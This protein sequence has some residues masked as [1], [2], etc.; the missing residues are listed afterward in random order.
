MIMIRKNSFRFRFCLHYI[1]IVAIPCIAFLIQFQTEALS[2]DRRTYVEYLSSIALSS[3][4]QVG[5]SQPVTIQNDD[6]SSSSVAVVAA[7]ADVTLSN[8]S[9]PENVE[10][11]D[12]V[13]MD[14]R[15]ARSD[16]ST[17][18]RDDLPD[19]FEN[20][21]LFQRITI[22]LYGTLMPRHVEK[23]LSYIEPTTNT[24]NGGDVYDV[25]NP[26]PSYSRSN[27][28]AL[29]QE[30]GLLMAGSI[31]S[32][33]SKDVAGT[34][35]LTYGSRVLPATLWIENNRDNT[36]SNTAK[37]TTTK[38][39]HSTKGLL[40]HRNLDVL[41]NFGI[42]TR[43]APS[44][45]GSNT[46]FGQVLWDEDTLKFFRNLEDIPT[47]SVARP[48]DYDDLE[49]TNSITGGEIAK[50]V[51][52]AQRQFFRGAAKSMGDDRVGKLY[53]GKL[54]RR[55]EVLQVGRV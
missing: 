31:S 21:V 6:Q 48:P 50:T 28:P 32:L 41:P 53:D 35:A 46:V 24:G 4:V 18:I 47:Y 17:Y 33:R 49:G 3:S 22:G 26:Y 11:T 42:T 16:G 40:S 29:D 2:L 7:A 55:M 23:F 30:T 19:T 10:I 13:F 27:F 8:P 38:L 20:T 44:L 45:D 36:A 15:I 51:F 9:M 54:L 37:T 14:V 39:S 5:Q 34:T 43:P 1:Y 12:R 25:D 52:N